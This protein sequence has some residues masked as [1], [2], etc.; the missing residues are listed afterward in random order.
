MAAPQVLHE[1]GLKLL[2]EAL[3]HCMQRYTGS[4]LGRAHE[5]EGLL[6]LP[7]AD[8]FFV[9]RQVTRVPTSVWCFSKDLHLSLVRLACQ[10]ALEAILV[11]ALLLA[12][13][14]VPSQLLQ[15]FRLD[16]I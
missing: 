5:L 4:A 10:M 6:L 9:R 11:A 15:T 14:A 7:G 12:H 13:L 2:R 1:C 8:R 3:N 16:S